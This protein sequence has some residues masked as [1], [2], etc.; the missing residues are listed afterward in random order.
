MQDH[1]L[2]V[3]DIHGCFEEFMSLLDKAQYN[4]SQHRL[5]LT[6]DLI[7]KGPHSLKVLRWTFQNKIESVIGNHELK[8]IHLI[9]QNLPLPPSFQELQKE[10]GSELNQWIQYLKTWPA[11]I[12]EDDFLVVHAGL[13]PGEHPSQSDIENLVHIR[14]WDESLGQ[15]VSQTQGKPWHEYYKDE[16]LVIYGHWARQGFHQKENAIGL[17]SGCVYGNPLTGVFLPSR[18]IIQTNVKSPS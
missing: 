12:E 16:K 14:H 7:N 18:M 6:G 5:I 13:V 17:D 8:F 4:S 1:T 10:M 11:Y 2:I 15:R 9:E 3:G